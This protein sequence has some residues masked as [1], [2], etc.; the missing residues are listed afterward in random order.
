M[1]GPKLDKLEELEL[2]PEDKHWK[3][4]VNKVQNWPQKRI[5]LRLKQSA[6]F[7]TRQQAAAHEGRSHPGS[8]LIAK[9]RQQKTTRAAQAET[10]EVISGAHLL[11][12]CTAP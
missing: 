1:E 2:A 5:Q 6:V 12:L 8:P 9:S 3:S 10:E 11:R 4:I 7:G